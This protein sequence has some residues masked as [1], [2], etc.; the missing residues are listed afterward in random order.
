VADLDGDSAG[1]ITMNPA[2]VNPQVFNTPI[3]FRPANS[4]DTVY[5]F[6][7]NA[8]ASNATLSFNGSLI[9][10]S[11]NTRPLTLTLSG[12]N[13]GN[14]TIREIYGGD[15]VGARGAIVVSKTGTGTWIL[16]GANPNWLQKTSNQTPA[17]VRVSD[18][19]LALQNS[20]GLG[21]LTQNNIRV[22]G[23][24]TM[25]LDTIDLANNGI[26]LDGTGRLL[27]NGNS[28]INAVALAAT[29]TDVRL[30]TASFPRPDRQ[31]SCYRRQRPAFCTLAG[32]DNC[33]LGARAHSWASGHSTAAQPH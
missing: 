11:A 8:A 28:S 9:N 25:R 4:R 30:E 21:A 19:T 32:R 26:T 16:T 18:G 10:N 15:S 29:A 31:R 24:G 7:N 1:N 33:C 3:V 12:S 5:S 27:A 14:N 23:T 2:V 22:L 13:T 17:S 6:V 20:G